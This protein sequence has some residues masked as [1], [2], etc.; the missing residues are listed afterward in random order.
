MPL[1]GLGQQS[2][3]FQNQNSSQNQGGTPPTNS[4]GQNL[5]YFVQNLSFFNFE[6][7]FFFYLDS[8]DEAKDLA[9]MLGGDWEL[10]KAK[11]FYGSEIDYPDF[12]NQYN[13]S[14]NNSLLK[15]KDS[16]RGSFYIPHLGQDKSLKDIRK[17][18]T[19]RFDCNFDVDLKCDTI[20]LPN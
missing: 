9:N 17:A 1:A 11:D 18:F 8:D 16:N 4:L 10:Y 20:S 13:I 19:G 2:L 6:H 15:G 3:P 14:M 7:S 5:Y 12:P